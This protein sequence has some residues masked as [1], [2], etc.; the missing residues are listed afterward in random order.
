MDVNLI[1]N[2][3]WHVF[4]K[5][6]RSPL[7]QIFLLSTGIY[8]EE[9]PIDY[10]VKNMSS[11]NGV[12]AIPLKEKLRL[13]N[14]LIKEL[15]EDPK[16]LLKIM[17]QCSEMHIEYVNE[18]R[19][20]Y[21]KVYYSLTSKFLSQKFM[22]YIHQLANLGFSVTIPL[23]VEEYLGETVFNKFKNFFGKDAEK[24]Y[25]IVL[26]PIRAGAVLQEE[27]ALLQVCDFN[28]H[29][30]RFGWMKNV[31][32]KQEYYP[33]S[34]YKKKSS[35]I[36]NPESKIQKILEQ[37]TNE[38]KIFKDLLKKISKDKFLVAL[39]KTLNKSIYFRS[40]RTEIFYSS[41]RFFTPMFKEIG[42]RLGLANYKDMLY[43][44]WNEIEQLLNTGKNADQEL[45]DQRK[46]GYVFVS[47]YDGEYTHWEGKEMDDVL[48]AF[49][50]SKKNNISLGSEVIGQRAY[51]GKVS[52]KV[53]LVNTDS[54]LKKIKKDDVLVCHSTNI[55]YVPYLDKVK[56]IVTE[57]GGILSHASMIS[58]EMKI[59]SVVGT[60]T[61][62]KVFKDGDNIEV[63]AIKGIVQKVK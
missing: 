51:P 1:R 42:K 53:C 14:I 16:F 40:Y 18:W 12:V 8:N 7:M 30:F 11:F 9:I 59:V 52:G 5:R 38:K 21:E 13:K 36:T 28:Y 41:A 45:I 37:R 57:E 49:S 31:D 48:K 19:E 35:K 3:S 60:N 24:M 15:E 25:A 17:K 6:D 22:E 62:T 54:D 2:T 63:D 34:Y 43:L 26:N 29:Q 23:F 10:R 47:D 27:K 61:A 44:Y 46:K 50:S 58:R 55:N 20:M 4:H 33:V 39:V 32:Y 56:A